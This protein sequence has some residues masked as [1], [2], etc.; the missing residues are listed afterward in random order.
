M[1]DAQT[2]S[3][4]NFFAALRARGYDF[5]SGVPCSLFAGLYPVLEKQTEV[6]LVSAVREDDAL[7][8]AGG[9][10]IAGKKPVMLMQNSGL[11]NSL[12]VLVSLN[13]IYQIPALILISWRGF[14]GNDAPEHIIMGPAM[15]DIFD[16]VGLPWQVLD[17]A[18][19]D[20]QLAEC[21]K[22]FE[23]GKPS[24]MI[25]KKGVIA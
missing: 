19:I 15:T 9:A 1:S 8:Q 4:E 17:P 23:N 11:G 25:I 18:K 24:M 13:D 5:F 16:A 10:W 7:S 22:H 2:I 21:E 3:G 20:A 6:P 12:N 14:E